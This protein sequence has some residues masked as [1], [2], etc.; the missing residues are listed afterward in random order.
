MKTKPLAEVYSVAFRGGLEQIKPILDEGVPGSQCSK[1]ETDR[2]AGKWPFA[3]AIFV[4]TAQYSVESPQKQ[5]QN[6]RYQGLLPENP[7][8]PDVEYFPPEPCVTLSTHTIQ[9]AVADACRST[10]VKPSLTAFL[11]RATMSRSRCCCS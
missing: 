8:P 1:R 10:M 2:S 4:A 3:E 9:A 7:P 6:M 5:F 11:R